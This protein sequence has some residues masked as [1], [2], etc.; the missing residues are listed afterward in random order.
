MR[1]VCISDTHNK[2][3]EINIPDGDLLIHSGDLSID[4]TVEEIKNFNEWLGNLNHK[5]KIF[6]AGNHDFLFEGNPIT[7]KSLITNAIYLENS[8]LNIEGL[9]IWGS[10]ANLRF[11]DGAFNK[12]AGEDIKKVWDLI[13]DNTDIL[14]THNPPYMILDKIHSGKN[15][16]CNELAKKILEIKPK[17]CIFGHVHDG[18]GVQ[19]KDDIT[20]INAS[21]LNRNSVPTNEPIIFDI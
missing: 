20:Y 15:I 16:G 4:G 7:A 13:P 10:P 6:I 18:Y 12:E 19:K 1:I 3:N 14:I 2:H 9:N 5:Y 21:N 8:G 11:Y 17:L